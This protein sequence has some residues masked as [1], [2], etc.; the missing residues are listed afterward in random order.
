MQV[1]T[2]VVEG[3]WHAF[4]CETRLTTFGRTK[5]EAMAALAESRR[6]YERLT[7]LAMVQN[8]ERRAEAAS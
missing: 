5:E 4:D 8:G 2:Y 1:E 3:G 7:A 6:R